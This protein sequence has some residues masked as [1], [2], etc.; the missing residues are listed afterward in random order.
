MN[1]WHTL[2]FVSCC[3]IL[4][5]K[6]SVIGHRSF[7]VKSIW[8][9]KKRLFWRFNIKPMEQR[10]FIHSGLSFQSSAVMLHNNKLTWVSRSP[11]HAKQVL[12]EVVMEDNI[13]FP[14]IMEHQTIH[15]C[16]SSSIPA[17]ISFPNVS[18]MTDTYPMLSICI[19][20]KVSPLSP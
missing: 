5:L 13:K 11:C 3:S 6:L 4:T 7:E 20:S 10:C 19:P 9:L 2:L 8:D 16:L 1:N 14:V 15:I 17:K 12:V 18:Q